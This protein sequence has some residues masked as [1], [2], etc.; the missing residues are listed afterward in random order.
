MH[1]SDLANETLLHIYSVLPTISS[2]HALAS[3]SHHFHSLLHSSHRLP[4]LYHAAESQYGPLSD[5]IRL[6]THNA[7]Q[8]AHIPRPMPPQSLALLHQIIEVGRVANKW[9]SV[10]PSQKWRGA[11]S[12]SRRFLSSSEQYKLRRA[13][14]RLWLYTLAFHTPTNPRTTRL[15]PPIVRARAALLRPWS[16]AQLAEIIDL[17]AIFRQILQS[18]I[19]P[20]NGTVLRRHKA[21]Y[22]DD[23]FPLVAIT[24]P[25]KWS[26]EHAVFAHQTH[27][28]CTPHSSNLQ[29]RHH[30]S[31]K[32][33]NAYGMVMEGWGDEIAHYYVVE[34]MLK[35]DPG[36]LMYLY[37][38]VMGHSGDGGAGF[39]AGWSSKGMVESFLENCVGDWF[40]NN[41]ETVTETV[42]FVVGERG[43]DAAE[44]RDWVEGG[45]EGVCCREC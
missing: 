25:S 3:T 30:G 45:W 6:I 5:A 40:E 41:G 11:D 23:P 12:A 24:Q 43:G 20:S 22:P 29:H 17:Q 39:N 26:I 31:G 38:Q 16:T 7:S 34:D 42:G 10:Y 19:C 18:T 32:N 27:F 37:E 9:V 36:Q 1:L 33:Q 21:R 13:C 4:I 35:L 44:L 2:C 28:H 15:S 14:Y 8:S